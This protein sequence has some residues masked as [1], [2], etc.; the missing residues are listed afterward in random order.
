MR[1]IKI[2]AF[3]KINLALDVI[4]K[5]EDGYHEVEIIMQSINLHDQLLIFPASVLSLE[6]KNRRL[7]ID[8]R[9]LIIKAAKKL[10]EYTGIQRG[11]RIILNKRIPVGAG[12]G[13]GSADA[14]AA[15]MGLNELWALELPLSTLEKLAVSI[16]ADV[17]FCLTGGTVLA[18][19]I[20]E[21]LTNL[22]TLPAESV[23]LT[24]PPFTVSTAMVYK[25]LCLTSTDR[26]P[27]IKS[28]ISVINKGEILP[29]AKYWGNILEKATFKLFPEIK[30]VMQC[31]SDKGFLVRMT[32]SGPTLFMF[33][34]NESLNF[35]EAKLKLKEMGWWTY[36]GTLEGRGLEITGLKGE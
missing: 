19:G 3:A 26:H 30:E 33:Q 6:T 27:D 17:P 7:P 11:A 16:G 24:K 31:L 32:G 21:K 22:P 2:K 5:R 25:N 13:G 14:A 29:I 36:E 9:N 4:G 23:F 35:E 15:L 8:D 1:K 10:R 28:I 20:G 34:P 18:K 12:L